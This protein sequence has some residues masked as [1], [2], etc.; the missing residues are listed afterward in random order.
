MFNPES[1]YEN[2][3]FPDLDIV[4]IE[5]SF[6]V[7][8]AANTIKQFYGKFRWET[9]ILDGKIT[10]K[11]EINPTSNRC[12]QSIEIINPEFLRKIAKEKVD[13]SLTDLCF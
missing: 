1:N 3:Y 8:D 9:Y 4:Q 6:Q 7:R 11:K 2:L 10:D 13:Y 5:G 12:N